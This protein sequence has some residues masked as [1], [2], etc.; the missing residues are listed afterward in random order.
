LNIHINKF[1]GTWHW[2]KHVISAKGWLVATL[3]YAHCVT[4]VTRQRL[5]YKGPPIGNGLQYWITKV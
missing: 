1:E 3:S 4:V 2:H 5:G